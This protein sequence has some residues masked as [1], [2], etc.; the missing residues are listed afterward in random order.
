[1]LQHHFKLDAS[2]DRVLQTLLDFESFPSWWPGLIRL[3][4]VARPAPGVTI[5]NA[6]FKRKITLEMQLEFRHQGDVISFR[7]LRGIFKRYE[8]DWVISPNLNGNGVTWRVTLRPEFSALFPRS[9]V[10]HML[11]TDLRKL[12]GALNQQLQAT[13]R[14]APQT[15][16]PSFT[17]AHSHMTCM[18]RTVGMTRKIPHVFHTP[19]GLEVWIEGRPY[20]L[21]LKPDNSEGAQMSLQAQT[22]ERQKRPP[23]FFCLLEYPRALRGLLR[24]IHFDRSC[25]AEQT[26]EGQ[27]VLVL[28][29][30]LSSDRVT[31]RLRRFIDRLG[32]TTYPWE[33]GRN[34]AN[35]EDMDALLSKLEDIYTRHQQPITLVGWSLG[36]IYARELAKQKSHLIQKVIT[37]GAP[38]NGINAPNHVAWLYTLLKQGKTTAEIEDERLSSLPQPPPVPT[39]AIYSK[40]DGVVNG[41]TCQESVV[42][43]MRQNIEVQ[44]GHIL[45]IGGVFPRH[46]SGSFDFVILPLPLLLNSIHLILHEP[47][48]KAVFKLK[49]TP[50][51]A[52]GLITSMKVNQ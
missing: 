6:V 19:Q 32:Y 50:T 20:L 15:A 3:A 41:E 9:M 52:H 16:P 13:S 42:D 23:L 10:Q 44:T 17:A 47:L 24:S 46:L 7:Q 49:Q 21:P 28:P 25:D 1:M 39:V 31:R 2:H 29:G 34:R 37:L 11:R 5:A 38:F 48:R 27:P 43:D 35:L 30:F 22:T 12:G 51:W 33:L 45:K 26:G 36:G 8:G 18:A 14:V 40:R 4:I